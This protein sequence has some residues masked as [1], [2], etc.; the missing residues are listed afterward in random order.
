MSRHT[1]KG[2]R[3]ESL[4]GK[5]DLALENEFYL[6]AISICYAIIE[7]RLRSVLIKTH[8]P[9]LGKKHKVDS[10]LKKIKA[11]KKTDALLAKYFTPDLLKKIDDWKEERNDVMHEL[12]EEGIN[13]PK[14]V[15]CATEGRELLAELAA[16]IMRWK[17]EF[18]KLK[19]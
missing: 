10:C 7:E 13:F 3:F 19:K 8:N 5:A 15:T 11:V 18:T 14:I 1:A 9:T 6:E 16:T 12:A 2:N 4:I 17:K